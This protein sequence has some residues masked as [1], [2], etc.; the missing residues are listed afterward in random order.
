MCRKILLAFVVCVTFFYTGCSDDS[1]SSS[2]DQV[3][4]SGKVIDGYVS[5]AQVNVYSDRNFENIIG[6]G[7]TDADGN[8]SINVNSEDIPPE[9]YL[10]SSGG[11]DN[12]T[13]L[14]APTMVFIGELNDNNSYNISPL[15]NE[16]FKEFAFKNTGLDIDQAAGEV[17]NLMEITSVSD[18]YSDPL[19][20]PLLMEKLNKVLFSGTLLSS[21][22]PGEYKT[23]GLGVCDSLNGQTGINVG[24]TGYSNLW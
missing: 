9:I 11:I 24:D 23:V 12:D 6:S 13:G 14:V 2:N 7:I 19:L 5:N 4:L 8:F 20:S 3:Q 10:K 1:D 17:A 16:I 15:T 18:L 22:A 21:L